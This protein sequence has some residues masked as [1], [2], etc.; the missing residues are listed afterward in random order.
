MEKATDKPYEITVLAVDDDPAMLD[1]VA[2]YLAARSIRVITTHDPESVVKLAAAEK[3]RLVISDLNMPGMD[4][5]TLLKALKDNPA[6]RDIPVV[7]LTS[8]RESSDVH[9][10]LTSGAEAYLVKPVDWDVSWP[11]IQAILLRS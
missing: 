9:A 8:S 6:T 5:V 1:V 2:R 10:A 3:P 11:K 7:L 4:G